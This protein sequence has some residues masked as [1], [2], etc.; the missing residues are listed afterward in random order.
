MVDRRRQVQM[1]VDALV[2]LLDKIGPAILMVHSQSGSYPWRVSQLRPA[3]VKG[4]VAL[5]P[6]GPPVHDVNFHGAPNWFSDVEALKSYGI[7]DIPIE[8]APAVTA[9][10]PLQFVQQERP[11][12]PDLVRCWRQREPARKLVAIGDRP[13]LIVTAEASFY[14]SYNHCTVEYLE[15]A[16][17]RPT[18]IRL[19]DIGLKGNGH[20]MMMERNSDQVAGVVADWLAKNLAA[21]E[22][23]AR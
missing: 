3:Q 18:H 6:T 17:V 4:I 5:E 11:N 20:M 16:G 23:T 13:I 21:A 1:N 15:Q 7:I 10:S 12:A 9:Q 22:A 14:A 8:Y 2:A 19:A